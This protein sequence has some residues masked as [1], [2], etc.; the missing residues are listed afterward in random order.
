[1]KNTIKLTIP[2]SFKGVDYKPSSVID[3]D[4]FLLGDQNLDALFQIVAT[5]NKIS[6]YSYEYEV[7]EASP[8]IFSDPTGMA[9]DFLS[10][11]SFDF[12]GFKHYKNKAQALTILQDIA[13]NTLEIDD[14]EAH[15]NLKQALWEA[16]KAGRDMV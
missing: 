9:C 1:M 11:D 2:F 5:E 6:N 8:K 3:L 15:Q 7:L 12:E 13:K 14:L 10:G 16:Y 4:T